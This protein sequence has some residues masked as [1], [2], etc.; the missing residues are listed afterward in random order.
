MRGAKPKPTALRLVQGGSK[1]SH[2]P[3]NTNEPCAPA[4]LPKPPPYLSAAARRIWRTMG[5]RLRDAGLMSN[6]DGFAFASY[7]QTA[8]HLAELEAVLAREGRTITDQYGTRMRPEWG[9]RIKCV[10]QLNVLGSE[11]GL[12]PSSRSR[13][14]VDTD[15]LK[16]QD[17]EF[18]RFLNRGK[19]Q[20]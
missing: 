12:S 7:C 19:L 1:V 8:A 15:T 3:M 18:E 11:F 5:P 10:Q 17:D 16:Q 13:V 2:R 14:T 4:A 9:A 20:V 6:L